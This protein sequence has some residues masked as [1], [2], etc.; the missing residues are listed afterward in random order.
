MKL[1]AQI[2]EALDAT[3]LPWTLERGTKHQKIRLGGRFVAIL[4]HG[5][6]Q[7]VHRR[8]LLNTI[9]QIRRAAQEV[10]TQ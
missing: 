7:T 4:P 2:E 1:P 3:G 9:A 5:K 6:E 8:S 10:A